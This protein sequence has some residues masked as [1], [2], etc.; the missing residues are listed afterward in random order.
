M[1]ETFQ[2]QEKLEED[3]SIRENQ[4]GDVEIVMPIPPSLI[5]EGLNDCHSLV[6]QV[7]VDLQKKV[8]RYENEERW[9]SISFIESPEIIKES[10][11]I[12]LRLNSKVYGALISLSSGHRKQELEGAIS[13]RSTYAQRFHEIL[14]DKNIPF[15]YSIEDLRNLLKVE[16][17]YKSIWIFIAHVIEP[18]K[19]ELDKKSPYSFTYEPIYEKQRNQ[20]G[21]KKIIAITFTPSSPSRQLDITKVKE[22]SKHDI[23]LLQRRK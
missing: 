20:K 13:F 11:R 8:I 7:L 14:R 17:K 19:K 3:C 2:S 22:E 9:T 21:R 23:M 5:E 10:H 4:Y 12:Q 16:N 15:T 18:A 6:E 1:M